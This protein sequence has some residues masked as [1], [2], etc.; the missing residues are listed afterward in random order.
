MVVVGGLGSMMGSITGTVLLSWLDLQLR[1]IMNIPYIG[2]WLEE[3]PASNAVL[4]K[5]SAP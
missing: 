3:R 2:E 5:R 1:N 4:F